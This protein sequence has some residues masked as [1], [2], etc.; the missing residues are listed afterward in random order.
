MLVT[1]LPLL[2]SAVSLSTRRPI[3]EGVMTSVD[4]LDYVNIT[5]FQVCNK[6]CNLDNRYY[7]EE[8]T[9]HEGTYFTV[10]SITDENENVLTHAK[11]YTQSAWRRV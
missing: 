2:A 4:F 9:L 6:I 1:M 3:F 7:V 8:Y 5:E 10:V 11:E